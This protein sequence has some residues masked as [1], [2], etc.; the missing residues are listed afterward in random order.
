MFDDDDSDLN[1]FEVVD[2]KKDQKVE[3]MMMV[4]EASTSESQNEQPEQYQ[5]KDLFQKKSNSESENENMKILDYNIV[6]ET[7]PTEIYQQDTEEI[8]DIL[9]IE[10]SEDENIAHLTIDKDSSMEMEENQLIYLN[11]KPESEGQFKLIATNSEIEEKVET[12]LNS[13]QKKRKIFKLEEDVKVFAKSA[14]DIHLCTKCNR[15]F[16][17]RTNLYRHLQAHDG[18]KNY[19]CEVCNKGFTQSGSLKQHYFIHTGIS[20]INSNRND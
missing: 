20:A 13:P 7:E 15:S 10:N 19:I 18:A 4:Q 2:T 1:Q 16:S 3:R 8:Y 12:S 17:T 5:S 9:E 6:T 14:G 11:I